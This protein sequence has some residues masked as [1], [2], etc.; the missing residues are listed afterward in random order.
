MKIPPQMLEILQ[1]NDR[2][3]GGIHHVLSVIRPWFEDNKLV[4]FPEYTDH[5][6]THIQ[7]VFDTTAALIPKGAWELLT[8]EDIA[9]LILGIVLHDCA[10]HLSEDGFITLIND[11]SRHSAAFNDKP[12][13]QI[14]D[15]FMSE[16]RRFDERKLKALF[17]E[18]E[19]V[20]P[21]SLDPLKMTKRDRL[22]IGEFLRRHHPRLA[23]EIA[24]TGVPGPPDKGLALGPL[25]TN[26]KELAGVVARS[27]G[28]DLRICVDYLNSKTRWG[29]RRTAGVHVTYLMAL[30]RV[31]DYLQIHPGRAPE[32]VLRVRA[33][34]S[35]VSRGEWNAHAAITDIHQE[36]DDPEAFW[37]EAAP[38]NIDTYLKL[39]RL[40][41]DIQREIDESWAI[42][43]EVYGPKESFRT[44]GL[45]IRRL[46][47][48]L[49]D[50]ITFAKTV[51]YV[52]RRASLESQGAELLKLLIVPLYG[53]NPE[54]GI[55]ELLQNGVDACRELKDY[56]VRNPQ[57][58]P[59]EFREQ[60]A[61]VVIILEEKIDGSKWL[62]V[63]DKGIGMTVD[64]IINYFLKAGASFRNSD[65]WR[66]LH[67]D[68]E[69]KTQVLRSGRF[70]IGVLA[71]F[72]LGKEIRVTTRHISA[73][74]DEGIKFSCKLED[75]AI[76]LNR[77]S[78]P[79]G[80]EIK[81]NI[82]TPVY[83]MLTVSR[84]KLNNWDWYCLQEPSVQRKVANDILEQ[85]Y[86][87]PSSGEAL[88]PEWRRI[89][90]PKYQDIHWSYLAQSPGFTC[91]GIPIKDPEKNMDRDSNNR[92]LQDYRMGALAGRWLRA[93]NISVHDPYG[94]LPLNLQRTR[95]I[96]DGVHFRSELI[97]DICK[98][99]LAYMIVYTPK[100]MPSI[101]DICDSTKLLY[102]N[103]LLERWA[104]Y[105]YSSSGVSLLSKWY[106]QQQ[107]KSSIYLVTSNQESN[108]K[109]LIPRGPNDFVAP[110]F[111][112]LY[113]DSAPTFLHG[114]H[115]EIYG[116]IGRRV[117]MTRAKYEKMQ[118]E[119]A[120][121]V[122]I[123]FGSYT[124]EWKDQTWILL[125][126][127]PCIPLTLNFSQI[128]R[129]SA[130]HELD[131][132][133]IIYPHIRNPELT[134]LTEQLTTSLTPAIKVL[135]NMWEEL[136]NFP[137]IP[138]DP[139][140]RQE[141]LSRAFKVLSKHIRSWLEVMTKRNKAP[142]AAQGDSSVL[143]KS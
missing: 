85:R 69:G 100:E 143:Y 3:N 4:F 95:L 142:K 17:D 68:Q 132:F 103:G 49:D 21:P 102:Y 135:D 34:K 57:T 116:P 39:R 91:N 77:V 127:G 61:D 35:P 90:H 16:A 83:Q 123:K 36:V 31:A 41:T 11:D 10:M 37:V 128:S 56:L 140:E 73:A 75:N 59:P 99:I 28:M 104:W 15:E 71:G 129:T 1:R 51:S 84:K 5:G 87:L 115:H 105:A 6:V 111:K 64:T 122:D 109:H 66:K 55:R 79:V 67:E 138:Y 113:F 65:T 47:S 33:L 43:G 89:R 8:P 108:L 136:I 94:E 7:E 19:P 58:S 60:T 30:V 48:N 29:A 106:Y 25:P 74:H 23:N 27:H 50:S 40:L 134:H 42:L 133:A 2:L 117:L 114:L 32:E 126:R 53:S 119:K 54:V 81:I 22:L 78:A 125:R 45:T 98:D 44:L 112:H 92:Q 76:Q 110:I 88:P 26:I 38:K 9:T 139:R 101:G 130:A 131:G 12:W 97:Q 118:K 13:R 18:V 70:G 20:R 46:R 72:L 107:P 24:L 52:P 82:Q 137:Y 124:I 93:P 141:K 80:T 120:I 121:N 62:T 96:G 86:S 14:W 63:S